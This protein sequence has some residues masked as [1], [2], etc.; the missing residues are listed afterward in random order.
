MKG[1][2]PRPTYTIAAT[3]DLFI[4]SSV[5]A[6]D[7]VVTSQTIHFAVVPAMTCC[8][9]EWEFPRVAVRL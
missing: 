6:A 4:A 8:I 1:F 5:P 2:T 7:D 9:L 3:A